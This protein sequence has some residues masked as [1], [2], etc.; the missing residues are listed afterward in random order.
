MNITWRQ[1]Y[2]NLLKKT[3]QIQ[4]KNKPNTKINNPI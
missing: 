2:I 3:T 1:I 4:T